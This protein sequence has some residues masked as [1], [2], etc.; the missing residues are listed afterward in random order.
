MHFPLP[1][2]PLHLGLN[3]APNLHFIDSKFVGAKCERKKNWRHLMGEE[4][5]PPLQ[6][7]NFP[8]FFPLFALFKPIYAISPQN[9][10]W[11]ISHTEIVAPPLI[12]IWRA[13]KKFFL[14]FRWQ[15]FTNCL[16]NWQNFHLIKRNSAR[17]DHWH[18]S[19]QNYP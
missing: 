14:K 11:G 2:P 12:Q 3:F 7:C 10:F 16:G 4:P 6:W 1:P 8:S 5:S 15:F 9:K 13:L 17:W 19:R 18:S